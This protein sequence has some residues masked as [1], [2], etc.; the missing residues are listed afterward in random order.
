MFIPSP[1]KHSPFCLK[2]SPK[3]SAVSSLAPSMVSGAE[4]TDGAS[5]FQAVPR[6][7][8]RGREVQSYP[9]LLMYTWYIDELSIYL[10][11]PM[12]PNTVSEGTSPP[13]SYPKHFLA[14]YL[15]P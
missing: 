11:F 10:T 8:K 3:K 9:I 7:G 2:K 5:A 1:L 12:D 6:R 14:R 15:D 4:A 13:K